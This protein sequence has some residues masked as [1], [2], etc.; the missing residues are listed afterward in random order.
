MNWTN[1]NLI[2]LAHVFP[3]LAELSYIVPVCRWYDGSQS[4]D[5]IKLQFL[6]ICDILRD[7]N[8]YGFLIEHLHMIYSM[9]FLLLLKSGFTLFKSD[10]Y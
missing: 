10:S 4:G 6:F 3:V 5:S 2:I 9:L 7:A 8:V 1:S